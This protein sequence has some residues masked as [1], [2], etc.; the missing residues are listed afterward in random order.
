MDIFFI[1]SR[2]GEWLDRRGTFFFFFFSPFHLLLKTGRYF[3]FFL[4][5]IF[6]CLLS[7]LLAFHLAEVQERRG[8]DVKR[9]QL[10]QRFLLLWFVTLTLSHCWSCS[11]LGSQAC[12]GRMYDPQLCCFL[13]RESPALRKGHDTFVHLKCC[14]SWPIKQCDSTRGGWTFPPQSSRSHFHSPHFYIDFLS[15]TFLKLYPYWRVTRVQMR[16]EDL[17]C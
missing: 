13:S 15:K 9:F 2:A 4:Q 7:V 3:S 8:T 12:R 5:V 11:C 1:S 14:L 6:H 10:Q 17:S 16:E